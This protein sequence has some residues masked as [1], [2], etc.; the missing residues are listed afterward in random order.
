MCWNDHKKERK[1]AQKLLNA[2]SHFSSKFNKF[3]LRFAVNRVISR[4]TNL[5]KIV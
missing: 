1:C 3:N 4:N 5:L 2:C